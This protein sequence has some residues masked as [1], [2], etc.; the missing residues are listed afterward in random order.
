MEDKKNRTAYVGYLT[1][2]E[3]KKLVLLNSDKNPKMIVIIKVEDLKIHGKKFGEEEKIEKYIGCFSEEQLEDHPK[4][5]DP[6]YTIEPFKEASGKNLKITLTSYNSLLE[7]SFEEGS[8][9]NNG[10]D[11]KFT[12]QSWSLSSFKKAGEIS[13]FFI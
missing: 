7:K 6:E 9:H 4:D 1:N 11:K 2:D 12:K 8:F 3:F 10:W 5:A 13:G